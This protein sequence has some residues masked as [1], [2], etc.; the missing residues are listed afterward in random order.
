MEPSNKEMRVAEFV[1]EIAGVPVGVRSR[2]DETKEFLSDYLSDREPLLSVEPSQEDLSRIQRSF[3]RMAEADGEPRREYHPIFLEKNAVH[4]LL[5]DRL[6]AFDVLLMHGSALCMDGQAYIFTAP[7]GT[8]KSTHARL[9]REA[10]GHRV[11]MI[12]D[13]KPLLRVE[14]GG[15]TVYGSPWDGKH[16]LSR[17]AKAPLKA[18]VSLRRKEENLLEPLSKEEAFPVLMSQCYRPRNPAVMARVISL[19]KTILDLAEFYRLSCNMSPE[20]A[21]V[22]YRGMNPEA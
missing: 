14:N 13:D 2:F 22:A 7:S 12:N 10:F 5:A 11:W 19:E 6:V 4:A 16:R 9:W 21:Q 3:D 8:G 18:V 17:N 15:V 1:I 20:A